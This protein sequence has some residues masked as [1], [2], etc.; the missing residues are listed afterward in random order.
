[1]TAYVIAMVEVTDPERYR[2]Y[3]AA[4]PAAVAAAGGRFIVRGGN[5][6][7]FEGTLE[8]S[9]IVV[10]EFPDRA[11]ARAFYDSPAYQAARE[12]RLGAAE[13]TMIVVD[14]I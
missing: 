14:G 7:A 12:K 13:F 5:P 10:L 8:R 6:E 3:M 4:T 11:A 2:D 1:M 9:R